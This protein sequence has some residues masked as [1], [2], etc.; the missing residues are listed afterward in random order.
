MGDPQQIAVSRRIENRWHLGPPMDLGEIFC[1]AESPLT[2]QI[3]AQGGSGFRFGLEQGDLA[4][5]DGRAKLFKLIAVHRP[6]NVWWYGKDQIQNLLLFHNALT[7]LEASSF[8]Y[9]VNS[10]PPLFVCMNSGSTQERPRGRG[11]R[12]ARGH[13]PTAR[14]RACFGYIHLLGHG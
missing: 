1:S 8:L 14:A 4:Q 10:S 12:I 3:Q 5:A 13:R 11:N 9:Q 7:A 6:R 2:H